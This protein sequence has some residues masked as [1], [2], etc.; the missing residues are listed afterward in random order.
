MARMENAERNARG[1]TANN[2]L[3]RQQLFKISSD[4]QFIR[5]L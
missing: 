2:I 5:V 4:K 1:P 3:T